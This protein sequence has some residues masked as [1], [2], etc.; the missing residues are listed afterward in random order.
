[1]DNSILKSDASSRGLYAMCETI[2]DR[3][4]LLPGDFVFRHN[5]LQIHHVGVYIGDGLVIECKGRDDGVVE[6]DINASG[7]SYWNRYGRFAALHNK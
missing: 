4:A 7:K 3:S 1:M 5:G 2:K 6:R